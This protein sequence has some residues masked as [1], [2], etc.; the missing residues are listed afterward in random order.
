MTGMNQVAEEAEM[1]EKRNTGRRAGRI[2]SW[3]GL[4][5][6]PTPEWHEGQWQWNFR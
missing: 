2:N 1:M 3:D 5:D 4:L 6:L